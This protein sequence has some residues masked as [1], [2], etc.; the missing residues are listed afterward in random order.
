MIGQ[1][2]KISF[3]DAGSLEL[4]NI[5]NAEPG[6]I[7][8]L[9][10]KNLSSDE[11]QQYFCE[12][13]SE[14]LISALS[15][16]KKLVVVAGN[17]SFSYRENLKTTKEIGQELGVRYIVDGS[18]RKLGQKLRINSS[19][20]SVNRKTTVWS[21]KFDATIDE[22]FDIQDKLIETIVSTVAGRVEADGIRQLTNSRPE[23]LA[24]YDLVLKGLEFHRRNEVTI[25]NTKKAFELFG[26]AGEIDPSYA[27][28][29]AWKA[30][31][32]A[33]LS[34]WEP[35]TFGKN[36]IDDCFASL[37]RTLELDPDDPE[38][39][40]NM[41]VIK[42]MKGEYD[43]AKYHHQRATELCPSDPFIIARYAGF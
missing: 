23:K 42:L 22:I 34:A 32:M 20:V 16:F 5:E 30:C 12:G 2:L 36:W 7:A 18:V 28:A 38:G 40:R 33:N 4:K 3:E 27:R 14:D 17:A 19:L 37:T 21:N 10:F 31:S 6:S 15:R 1:K 41:G 9:L 43:S 26:K 25:D 8:V 39:H 29:H 24:T 11:E 13:F 35:D